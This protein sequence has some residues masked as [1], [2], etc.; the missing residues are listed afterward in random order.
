ML[1][2]QIALPSLA[3]L[4]INILEKNSECEGRA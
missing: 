3:K 4:V 2:G 1:A